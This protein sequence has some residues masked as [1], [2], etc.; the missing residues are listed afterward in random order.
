MKYGIMPRNL[1]SSER[2]NR[3]FIRTFQRCN[4]LSEVIP[5]ELRHRLARKLF[6]IISFICREER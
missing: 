6:F 4:V 5:S 3:S 2:A 1:Y